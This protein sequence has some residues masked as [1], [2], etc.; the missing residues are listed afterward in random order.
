MPAVPDHQIV[1]WA[2]LSYVKELLQSGGRFY[3]YEKGFI[4]AKVIIADDLAF[5]GSPNMDIRSFCGQF[6]LGA[7]FFDGRIVDRLV[8]D[9]VR[10]LGASREILLP[11]FERRSKF[12][13]CKEV[14]A[15]LL[16]PL[17]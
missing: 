2:S 14:F 13:K 1:H 17:F 4:H 8:H 12:Q 6:E 16:S 11:Q 10:D 9:F 3:F 5:S 7:V 15:R